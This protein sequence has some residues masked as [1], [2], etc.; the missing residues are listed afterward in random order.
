[1]NRVTSAHVV[2]AAEAL[3]GNGVVPTG[4]K[5]GAARIS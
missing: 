2:L 4:D 5:T 1:M 3:L